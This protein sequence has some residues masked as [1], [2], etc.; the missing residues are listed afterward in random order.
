MSEASKAEMEEGETN[1]APKTSP[2]HSSSPVVHSHRRTQQDGRTS[3]TFAWI[4]RTINGAKAHRS[5]FPFE[6]RKKQQYEAF[7]VI[8]RT[9][10]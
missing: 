6:H 2:G 8:A 5:V 4:Y 10:L 1:Q 9:L 3:G 7:N